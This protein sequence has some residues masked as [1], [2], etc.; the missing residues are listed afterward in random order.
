MRVGL[1]NKRSGC[2]GRGRARF[3]RCVREGAWKG[4]GRR[5]RVAAGMRCGGGVCTRRLP[6]GDLRRADKGGGVGFGGPGR[7]ADRAGGP[8]PPL[9]AA[10]GAAGSPGKEARVGGE[11]RRRWGRAGGGAAGGGR[12]VRGG[13]CPR[14]GSVTQAAGR[15]L[16]A[17]RGLCLFPV[18]SGRRPPMAAEAPRGGDGWW[19][20]P[21]VP[22]GRG[23]GLARQD[24]AGC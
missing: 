7:G 14:G 19:C 15:G 11:V 10:L 3:R 2:S 4:E 1:K 21:P 12:A 18:L 5:R 13:R 6:G 16:R 22:E 24:G 20:P 8:P 17:R 9:V 23:G